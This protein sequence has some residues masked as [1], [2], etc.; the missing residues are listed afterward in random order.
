MVGS[1]PI[2]SFVGATDSGTGIVV[3]T[4]RAVYDTNGIV[5]DQTNMALAIAQGI[6]F[7]DDSN[8]VYHDASHISYHRYV[9]PYIDKVF[10]LPRTVYVGNT[11]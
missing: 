6:L 3:S 7:H 10:K 2:F 8:I 4:P 9:F 11:E 1:M 5:T